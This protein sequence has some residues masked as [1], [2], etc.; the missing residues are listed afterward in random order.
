VLIFGNFGAPEMGVAGAAIGTVIGAAVE[1]AIPMA[2]FL[3][4]KYA[5]EFGTRAAWRPQRAAHRRHLPHRLARRAHVRQRDGVLDLS[6]GRLIPRAAEAAGQDPVLA[7]TAGWIGLRYM[8]LSFMPTVGLSIAI[9]AIVGKCMGMNRPDLAASRTWLAF[10]LGLAYMGACGVVFFLFRGPLVD[11]FVSGETAEADRALIIALGLAGLIAAA[12]FQLFDAIAIM[13]SGALRGAGDTVWPGVAT[14]VLSWTCIVGVGHLLIETAPRLGAASP[15][16]GAAAFLIAL[17]LAMLLADQ[18]WIE[19]RKRE[20]T[21]G[22]HHARPD[23][24]LTIERRAERPRWIAGPRAD[25][26]QGPPR[27]PGRHGRCRAGGP[28]GA[29]RPRGGGR[30][31][32]G[33]RPDRGAWPKGPARLAGQHRSRGHRRITG[34]ARAS[35][36]DRVAGPTR[37]RRPSGGG[38][39]PRGGRVPA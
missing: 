24:R 22:R 32:R 29:T 33:D 31:S 18:A 9:T 25:R 11:L 37:P 6:D 20:R 16:I 3:S 39:G 38:R 7:N 2:I 13:L 19:R 26:L 10:R 30:G 12:I 17:G 14:L 15:W 34:R 35:G 27:A 23:G 1:F 28:R 8:H 5:R 36:T 4:P 21:G